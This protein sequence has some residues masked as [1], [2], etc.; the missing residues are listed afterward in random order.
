MSSTLSF[1][2]LIVLIIIGGAGTL[3]LALAVVLVLSWAGGLGAVSKSAALIGALVALGGVFT[4]Q[5][6]GITLE[7]QRTQHSMMLD[8]RRA[9]QEA[10]QAYLAKMSEL[11]LDK[12]L[13]KRSDPYDVVRVTARAQTLSVLERLDGNRKRTVLLFLW[14]A[15][16]INRSDQQISQPSESTY[17]AHYVG[18][19]GADLSEANLTS[20]RL[21]STSGRG[22]ASLRETNLKSA[23][24]S[25][26]IL[27]GVDLRGADLSEADLRGADLRGADLSGAKGVTN[28]ELELQAKSLAGAVMPDGSIHA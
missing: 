13:H 15:R 7:Q 20:A 11:L 8:E 21:T 5:M 28:E 19:S 14:D 12:D 25:L 27:C 18:L 10:L 24:L 1:R 23:K 17:Y 4:A 9:Q 16:L 22:S 6:V 26:A 2:N 3:A